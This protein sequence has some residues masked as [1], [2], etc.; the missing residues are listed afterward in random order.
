MFRLALNE[1][2]QRIWGSNKLRNGCKAIAGKDCRDR[3][4]RLGDIHY[5][6]AL[7]RLPRETL[8]TADCRL[9]TTR[10]AM[11]LLGICSWERGGQ[12][13]GQRGVGRCG[14]GG[15]PAGARAPGPA[16][17]H[18]QREEIPLRYLPHAAQRST[19]AVPRP[20]LTITRLTRL[21]SSRSLPA[22]TERD[23]G[24]VHGAVARRGFD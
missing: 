15:P 1:Q 6:D 24:M 12:R 3:L 14:R 23:G 5:N 18:A 21:L 16:P 13:R 10:D 4:T 20:I 11:F 7:I 22:G 9:S 8:Q 2:I 17:G 19:A